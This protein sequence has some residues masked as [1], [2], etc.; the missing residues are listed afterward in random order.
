[1]LDE[2]RRDVVRHGKVTNPAVWP[3]MVYRAGRSL[4]ALPRPLRKLGARIYGL[5]CLGLEITLGTVLYRETEIGDGL[6]LIHGSNIRVHPRA[7]LGKRVRLNH[8]VTIGMQH[9][10]EGLPRIGN[11]VLIGAGA[12][13]LGPIS[14]GDGAVISACSLVVNDVPPGKI[15]MGVPAR[16]LP[17]RPRGALA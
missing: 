4:D 17:E 8:G 12:V 6:H 5:A 7:V 14:I 3:L 15:A 1:M 16:P 13:V 10:V 9:R 2:L 11:D